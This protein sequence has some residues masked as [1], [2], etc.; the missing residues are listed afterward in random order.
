MLW[1]AHFPFSSAPCSCTKQQGES[2]NS[3]GGRAGQQATTG[4]RAM[5]A[6]GRWN[7]WYC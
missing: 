4:G 3:G 7:Y 1:A 2:N 5:A 6:Q